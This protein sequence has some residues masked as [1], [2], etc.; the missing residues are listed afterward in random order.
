LF[1]SSENERIC[2]AISV[3]FIIKWIKFVWWLISTQHRAP[4]IS[5]GISAIFSSQIFWKYYS[6]KI[7]PL[8]WIPIKK[9]TQLIF[10]QGPNSWFCTVTYREGWTCFSPWLILLLLFL[11]GTYHDMFS[12]SIK[13]LKQNTSVFVLNFLIQMAYDLH[14]WIAPLWSMPKSGSYCYVCHFVSQGPTKMWNDHVTL[15]Q[16]IRNTKNIFSTHRGILLC[17]SPCPWNTG[18]QNENKIW[19]VLLSHTYLTRRVLKKDKIP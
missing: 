11:T 14:H 18:K 1:Y 2:C 10:I 15:C 4:F 6:C 3:V 16:L 7:S 9:Y 19:W 5:R 12:N 8:N 13:R 17:H